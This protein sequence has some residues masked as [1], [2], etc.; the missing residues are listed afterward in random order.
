MSNPT[1]T[2]SNEHN[3]PIYAPPVQLATVQKQHG[4]SE[5]FYAQIQRDFLV[6]S[7]SYLGLK[8]HHEQ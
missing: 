6:T 8:A 1:M 2:P 7:A 5:D 4:F 3:S